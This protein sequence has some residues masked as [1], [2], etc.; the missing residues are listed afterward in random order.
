MNMTI[1]QAKALREII[2]KAAINLSDEAV[3]TVPILF[4][5]MKYDGSTILAGTC[6]NWNGQIKRTDVEIEDLVENNPDNKP[7]HWRDI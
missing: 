7:E 6:I 2:V 4:E 1:K 3:A 5:S